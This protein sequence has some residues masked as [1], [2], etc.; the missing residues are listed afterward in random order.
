[1]KC[2]FPIQNPTLSGDAK[3]QN[4]T[5]RMDQEMG[6]TSG[7]AADTGSFAHAALTGLDFMYQAI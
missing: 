2:F 5:S 7:G 4:L 3:V 6:R 1:M